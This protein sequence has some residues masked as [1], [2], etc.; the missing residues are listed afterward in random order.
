MASY[1]IVR[2]GRDY[3]PYDIH[4]VLT[5]TEEGSVVANDVVRDVNTGEVS[6]V[7]EVL[8]R[9]GLRP[10]VAHGGS[11]GSQLHKIG[12]D[13][14]LPKESFSTRELFSD[15]RLLLLAIV[16]LAPTLVLLIPMPEIAVF[17]VIALY[18]SCIWGL[19]FY[20]FFKTPQVT[21][22]TTITLFFLTQIFVFIVWDLFGLVR[23]NPF[24]ALVNTPFPI[25]LLGFVFG[26]GLS[27][28]LGKMI[29]LIII[30]R[31]A[32]EPVLPRTLVYYGLMSGIAFGVF[33][34]VQYQVLENVKLD[35]TSA[36]YANIARL[37]SL[38]FLHAIWCAIA[39]Y[40]VAY[41]HLYPRYRRSLYLLA[42]FIPAILHGL[43]DTFCQSS[44]VI[45]VLISLVG[46][47][48]LM[49]YLK[50]STD[51]RSRLRN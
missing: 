36:F 20:Y 51:Y 40:F 45:A 38:P 34:G 31:R 24:Y 17:Y 4:T 7:R 6:T 49:A 19:F 32:K 3:G 48:L 26:V 13:L 29:P 10:K 15:K 47:F 23:F 33:E 25:D 2:N 16:G 14:I 37:T 42:L 5:Y 27:E 8:K 50:R 39:G 30:C 22:R 43:Y 18:F 44:T 28:E 21:L 12:S 1:Y 46:V 41:A 11:I 9:A 35:Y